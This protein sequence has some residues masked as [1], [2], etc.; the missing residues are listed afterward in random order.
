MSGLR[1]LDLFDVLEIHHSRIELYGG[2]EGV[3]DIGM[4]QSAL[5][6]PQAG[7]GEKLFHKDIF[8]M[9]SAYWFHIARNHPFLD[10]NKRTALAACLVFLDLNGYEIFANSDDL[11]NFTVAISAGLTDKDRAAEF[12]KKYAKVI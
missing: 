3:R 12:L 2:I 6:Q 9:A 11:E 7:S 8:E 4:L 10:G 1:F 5:A